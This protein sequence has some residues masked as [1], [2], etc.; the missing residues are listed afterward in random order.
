MGATTPPELIAF[1]G[2][3]ADV[4]GVVLRRHFRRGVRVESKADQSPV[5]VADRETEQALRDAILAR[6][7]QH[8]VR[9]EELGHVNPSAEYVWVLDPIDG[10]KSFITGKP[11]FTT[12][13]GLLHRGPRGEAPV[14]GVIDQPIMRERW[15]GAT[16][17]PTT[18]N[19]AP[20]RVQERASLQDATLFTT[21]A[22]S[23]TRPSWCPESERAVLDHLID[24]VKLT[25]YSTDG[26]AF[27]LLASGFIDLVAEC[28]TEPHDFC[29]AIPVVLGAGGVISDW[30][31]STLD[32]G[33][34]SHVLASCGPILHAAAVAC[35][36][37]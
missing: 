7:P 28:G 23:A 29:A 36:G 1:A 20:C 4:A 37:R 21:G 31:G 19:G 14:L 3:L 8:G 13:I 6:Y 16:G 9:G 17:T 15:L 34:R 10:T 33:R 30:R 5:T 22:V 2:T 11:L 18:F 24:D 27:G 12:L 32:C 35:L 25:Q 26:Y